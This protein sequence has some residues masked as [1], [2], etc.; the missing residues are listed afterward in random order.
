MSEV[1]CSQLTLQKQH[2]IASF[3]I[4]CD[5]ERKDSNAPK[6]SHC[7]GQLLTPDISV[8]RKRQHLL[9]VFHPNLQEK[10]SMPEAPPGEFTGCAS[11][12]CCPGAFLGRIIMLKS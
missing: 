10:V 8:C 6:V 1:C 7:E 3:K 9:C 5:T 11:F 12:M 4:I 2:L